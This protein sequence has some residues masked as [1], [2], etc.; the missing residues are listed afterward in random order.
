M[1]PSS[2]SANSRSYNN[3][4]ASDI[5]MC[6]DRPYPALSRTLLAAACLSE[7]F[8]AFTISF[9]SVA[10]AGST[11]SASLSL[12]LFL[13]AVVAPPCIRHTFCPCMAGLLQSSPSRRLLWQSVLP[14]A[15]LRIVVPFGWVSSVTGA[16][17]RLVSHHSGYCLGLVGCL[18]FIV[19]I[20][21]DCVR[22]VVMVVSGLFQ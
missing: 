4:F 1:S 21:V 13:A 12:A 8:S 10:I 16:S 22:V 15:S 14:N 17:E 7:L 18:G 11:S 9:A 19:L 2:A 3:S 5:P 6:C 20:V